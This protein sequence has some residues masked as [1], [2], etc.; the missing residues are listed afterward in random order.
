M[1][2]GV[3][4]DVTVMRR[5]KLAP[6]KGS[7]AT[8][9]GDSS[10]S[11]LLNKLFQETYLRLCFSVQSMAPCQ[12]LGL[13]HCVHILEEGLV[14]ILITALVHRTSPPSPPKQFLTVQPVRVRSLSQEASPWGTATPTGYI[15]ES[16]HASSAS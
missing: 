5:G 13:T 14:E 2:K 10:L 1:L 3:G 6:R 8:G 9:G 12:V 7:N 15:N 11:S 16:R 4:R